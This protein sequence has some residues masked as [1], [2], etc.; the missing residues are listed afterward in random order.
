MLCGAFINDDLAYLAVVQHTGDV[1]ICWQQRLL[2]QAELSIHLN[3]LG[4]FFI[5]RKDAQVGVKT[6]AT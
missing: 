1:V 6:Q 4:R 3:G 5:V 2:T